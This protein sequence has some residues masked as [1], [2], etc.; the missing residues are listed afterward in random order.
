MFIICYKVS[1]TRRRMDNR[2]GKRKSFHFRPFEVFEVFGQLHE[3]NKH[4]KY[5]PEYII[6]NESIVKFRSFEL[7]N[8]RGSTPRNVRNL[9]K[10]ITLHTGITTL[11]SENFRLIKIHVYI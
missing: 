9:K 7:K 5:P 6:Y 10:K 4:L 2:I 1:G 11:F 3:Q 8:C